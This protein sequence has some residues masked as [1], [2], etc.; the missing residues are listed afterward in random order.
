MPRI[1][2]VIAQLLNATV[3]GGFKIA[4]KTVPLSQVADH[5][6]DDGSR[7]RVVFTTGLHG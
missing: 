2:H 5:W 6:S 1:Q 3:P 7:E 4:T